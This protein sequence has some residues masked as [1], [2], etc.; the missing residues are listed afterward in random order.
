MLSAQA[1]GSVPAGALPAILLA[2]AA[3]QWPALTSARD[4]AR[5]AS[6]KKEEPVLAGFELTPTAPW[7]NC[8]CPWTTAAGFCSANRKEEAN[9]S[10]RL[11]RGPRCLGRCLRPRG[12]AAGTRADPVR[13]DRV[14][15]LPPRVAAGGGRARAHAPLVCRHTDGVR[16]LGDRGLGV[17]GRRRPAGR[18]PRRVVC[19]RGREPRA[20]RRT[21][22]ARSGRPARLLA[23]LP[24][25]LR[26][27]KRRLLPRPAVPPPTRAA[28]TAATPTATTST[29]MPTNG[30]S[31]ALQT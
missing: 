3:K 14:Q 9:R 17:R 26:P 7:T 1:R 18:Q 5:S 13:A 4:P 24:G 22:P 12:A 15:A 11:T 27:A 6:T 16:V 30:C 28:G 10:P 31:R 19:D 2:I 21:V 25:P 29:L 20:I 23:R 8:D